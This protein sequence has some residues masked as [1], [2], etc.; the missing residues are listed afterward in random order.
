VEQLSKPS[1]YRPDARILWEKVRLIARDRLEG[2]GGLKDPDS[3]LTNLISEVPEVRPFRDVVRIAMDRYLALIQYADRQVL[4][5]AH[6]TDREIEDFL[7]DLLGSRE[8]DRIEDLL[9]EESEKLEGCPNVT[10]F[11][12][13][14]YAAHE[15][16]LQAALAVFDGYTI[17]L[18][19]LGEIAGQSAIYITSRDVD[20]RTGIKYLWYYQRAA[21]E[22][23]RG[24]QEDSVEQKRVIQGCFSLSYGVAHE[25]IRPEDARK[26]IEAAV[27]KVC[28]SWIGIKLN[29][30]WLPISEKY[31]RE[32]SEHLEKSF[33]PSMKFLLNPPLRDVS[34]DEP[35]MKELTPR[36][37]YPFSMYLVKRGLE[38]WAEGRPLEYTPMT[39]FKLCSTQEQ[40]RFFVFFADSGQG[41][42]V[43][44]LAFVSRAIW[45]G[46]VA[47]VLLS[48]P[49]NQPCLFPL[50]ASDRSMKEITG[51]L[52]GSMGVEPHPFPTLILN[53]LPESELNILKD[54]PLTKFDRLICPDSTSH[55]RLDVGRIFRELKK[56][57][58][59]LPD[60]K[61]PGAAL[62]I[63]NL[64]RKGET[65]KESPEHQ[66]AFNVW[67]E[68]NAY[69]MHHRKPRI[70]WMC[71]ELREMA[72][73][74]LYAGQ[75]GT[76]R[77]STTGE[78]S[79]TLIQMRGENYGMAA[80]CI[81]PK[82]VIDQVHTS[83]SHIFFR[84]LP[85]QQ[86]AWLLDRKSRILE[87]TNDRERE[88]VSEIHK[89][90]VLANT[91]LWVGY[92]RETQSM[93]L[94]RFCPP[95]T[96]LE[97]VGEDIVDAYRAYEK[98]TGQEIL[99]DH[100][101]IDWKT[102]TIPAIRGLEHYEEEKP[103]TFGGWPI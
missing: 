86:L 51:F 33:G 49:R 55:F 70:F 66:V 94:Y 39:K 2:R 79:E 60:P 50:P 3:D 29:M 19:R 32:F 48:D 44:Q 100:D 65:G 14:T 87:L 54:V 72:A 1:E 16:Y 11:V 13:A 62:V 28:W 27:W 102:I 97:Q 90:N 6:I 98:E 96:Y 17:A 21:I 22:I 92:S 95:P 26:F 47:V 103:R 83:A 71:D 20:Q 73:R 77:S 88:I 7:F 89:S 37:H 40:R 45:K 52:R 91:R 31:T 67:T 58:D 42:T 15:C 76:D 43:S 12:M 9:M 93:D 34:W 38:S 18:K 8:F 68:I 59:E 56:T 41:K 5:T 23:L 82:E 61:P 81:E 74:F 69:R 30:A 24:N 25:E 64:G 53:V 57:H 36:I 101:A 4:T 80:G 78:F 10:P 63:R 84:K 46:M 75:G 99:L 35:S 85:G